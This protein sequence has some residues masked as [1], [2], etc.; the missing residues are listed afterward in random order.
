MAADVQVRL[1]DRVQEVNVTLQDFMR[2]SHTK[3]LYQRVEDYTAVM[4]NEV[5]KVLRTVDPSSAL[6]GTCAW[7]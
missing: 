2:E 5:G 4:D 6:S 7:V 3:K 1:L